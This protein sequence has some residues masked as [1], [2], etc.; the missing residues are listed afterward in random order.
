MSEA[1]NARNARAVS[2]P[3]ERG[4]GVKLTEQ[5]YSQHDVDRFLTTGTGYLGPAERRAVI[6][7]LLEDGG[8]P[9][10]VARRVGCSALTVRR[11]RQALIEARGDMA[12]AS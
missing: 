12:V 2:E 4:Q 9:A 6:W 8:T 1:S 3:I 10:G 5:P 11:A 7:R